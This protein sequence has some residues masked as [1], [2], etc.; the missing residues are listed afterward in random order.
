MTALVEKPIDAKNL[1]HVLAHLWPRGEIEIQRLGLTREQLFYRFWDY[2]A[3]GRSGSLEFDGVPAAVT[4]IATEGGESFTWFQATPAFEQHAKAITKHIRRVAGEHRGPLFIYS[5]CV[6]PE[7]ERWFR[8]LRFTP[9]G[10]EQQLPT[11][12]TLRRFKRK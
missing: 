10:H 7:T 5:V 8:V 2:A 9:D 1:W 4:G 6:H 12:A 11:G 3:H